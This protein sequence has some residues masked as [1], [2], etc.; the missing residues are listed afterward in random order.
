MAIQPQF[1]SA[2][3]FREGVA[4]ARMDSGYV[5]IKSSGEVIARAMSNLQ[6]SLI[7]VGS[8]LGWEKERISGPPRQIAIPFHL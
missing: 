5:L 6:G 7:R 2:Y 1:E 8:C 3:Y 4:I